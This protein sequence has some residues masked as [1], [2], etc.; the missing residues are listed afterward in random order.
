MAYD[1]KLLKIL[2]STRKYFNNRYYTLFDPAYAELFEAI[3]NKDCE[4]ARHFILTQLKANK[5][6]VIDRVFYQKNSNGE[7]VISLADRYDLQE[8]LDFC[9]ITLIVEG[10]RL[11]RDADLLVKTG[12]YSEVMDDL[13]YSM[14]NEARGYLPAPLYANRLNYT[15]TFVENQPGKQ[16]GWMKIEPQSLA[17][18]AILLSSLELLDITLVGNVR[19]HIYNQI[20]RAKSFHA[21]NLYVTSRGLN[22]SPT[23]MAAF[24]KNQLII[25]SVFNLMKSAARFN[26]GFLNLLCYFIECKDLKGLGFLYC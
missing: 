24:G 15:K 10:H 21:A 3:E 20:F 12:R 19:R 22:F 1:I 9:F 8:F 23:E 5:S 16:A 14:S 17:G 26:R 4:K 2:N 6:N 11:N 25:D 7:T 18:M 13:N